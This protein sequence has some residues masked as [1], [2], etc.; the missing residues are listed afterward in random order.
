MNLM[1]AL[2]SLA[3]QVPRANVDSAGRCCIY[4]VFVSQLKAGV[5]ETQI[6]CNGTLENLPNL[7][8]RGR[9][10]LY[11]VGQQTNLLSAPQGARFYVSRLFAIQT[12]LK[13]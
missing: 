9:H 11:N 4:S 5:K 10:Y 13:R 6:F 3:P 1:Y 8:S 12:S 7:C 2:A